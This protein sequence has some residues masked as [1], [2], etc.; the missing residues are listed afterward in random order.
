MLCLNKGQYSGKVTSIKYLEGV[1]IGTTLYTEEANDSVQHYHENPHLSFLLQGGH[2]E[3]RKNADFERTPGDL[4][5]CHGGE[6]H[7]FVKSRFP[8][9][10]VNLEMDYKFLEIYGLSESEV[11]KGLCGNSNLKFLMLQ[12]YKDVLIDDGLTET[13][14]QISLLDLISTSNKLLSQSRPKWV[15]PL[16]EILN[17]RWN[18]QLTLE[19]LS[20]IVQVHPVTISKNFHKYFGCTFGEYMRKL[21]IDK[22][23]KMIRCLEHSLTAIAL[24]CGFSDQSHF[25]RTFKEKTGWLP[26]Q[27][28]LL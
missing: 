19:E 18:E 28:Q 22:S 25:I 21:R 11:Y 27:F 5:F 4:L 7:Q 8:S 3:K 9:R 6:S 1:T 2:I 12:M 24:E 15:D 20:T 23:I 10:N 14:I 13:S 16:Y 26:K 17:D